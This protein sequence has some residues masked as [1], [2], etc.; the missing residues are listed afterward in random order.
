MIFLLNRERVLVE[1]VELA[2]LK[3]AGLLRV[4]ASSV[5][6]RLDL[7]DGKVSPVFE[8]ETKEALGIPQAAVQEVIASIYAETMTEFAAR[9][10]GLRMTRREMLHGARESVA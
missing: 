10:E 4:P 6:A 3:I 5:T 7:K 8:V 2:R 1:V 9:M